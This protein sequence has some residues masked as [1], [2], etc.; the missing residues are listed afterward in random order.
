MTA[1]SP[2][3]VWPVVVEA[4]VEEEPQLIK[5]L[6]SAVQGEEEKRRRG[7]KREAAAVWK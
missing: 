7:R 3:N 4:A 1:S 6:T 2:T 5:C